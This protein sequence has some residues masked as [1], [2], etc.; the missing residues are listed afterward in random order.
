MKQFIDSFRYAWRGIWTVFVHERNMRV[1]GFVA[2]V[3]VVLGYC[4]EISAGEWIAIVLCIGLVFV[5]EIINTAIE[6]L[7]DLVQPNH[8]PLAGKVKDIAAGAVLVGAIVA[9]VVGIIVFARY[10]LPW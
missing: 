6:T 5:L 3:A 9:V 7:V 8:D 1:H 2:L 4:Y 10:V